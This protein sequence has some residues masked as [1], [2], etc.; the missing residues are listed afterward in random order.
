MITNFIVEPVRLIDGGHIELQRRFQLNLAKLFPDDQLAECFKAPL[1]RQITL[2]LFNPPQREEFRNPVVTRRNQGEKEHEV[3]IA[4]NIT[5][6]A[7]QR[8]AALQRM[9]DARGIDE[10]FEVVTEPPEDYTKL[11]RH[12]HPQYRFEPISNPK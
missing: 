3:A 10:P 7:V 6:T 4:L 12:K 11:R 2:K 1:T 8:A 5:Q 9:M